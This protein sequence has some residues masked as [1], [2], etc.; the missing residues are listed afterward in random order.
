M[1]ELYGV[2]ELLNLSNP[3]FEVLCAELYHCVYWMVSYAL[4]SQMTKYAV[5][6]SVGSS[7]TSHQ[8]KMIEGM[9]ICL[10]MNIRLSNLGGHKASKI[11]I[12]FR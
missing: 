9:A 12:A 3:I 11:I 7:P 5:S 2:G 6:K 4:S 10:R 8:R 1:N